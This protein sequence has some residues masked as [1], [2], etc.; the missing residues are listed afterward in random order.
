MRSVKQSASGSEDVWLKA[1][2][3][4]AI[5]PLFIPTLTD[6][7]PNTGGFFYFWKSH[8]ERMTC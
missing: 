5:A 1:P 2:I 6:V 8:V 4:R 3:T 7:F